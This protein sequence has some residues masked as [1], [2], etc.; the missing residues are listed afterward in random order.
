MKTIKSFLCVLVMSFIFVSMLFVGAVSADSKFE[1]GEKYYLEVIDTSCSPSWHRIIPAEDRFAL[2]MYGNA[3][4]LD[5]ETCLVWERMPGWFEYTGD[6]GPYLSLEQ[7]S[8]EMAM[9]SCISKNTGGRKG[10]H[11]PTIEQLMS[12]ADPTLFNQ[13]II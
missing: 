3:A 2:V 8:W 9:F 11:L 1:I 10:W 12:L 7:S 5:R 13:G 4:V 6:D